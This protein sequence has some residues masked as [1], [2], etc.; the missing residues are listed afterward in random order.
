[1]HLNCTLMACGDCLPLGQP[2]CKAGYPRKTR[3]RHRR[4]T[5]S[6]ERRKNLIHRTYRRELLMRQSI[7]SFFRVREVVPLGC[8]I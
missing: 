3:R 1:M 2:K 5:E 7:S 8:Y 6:K 4:T